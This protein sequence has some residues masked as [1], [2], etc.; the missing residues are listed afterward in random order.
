MKYYNLSGKSA[1]EDFV[2]FK[3]KLR[4]VQVAVR[5][6]KTGGNDNM[7]IRAQRSPRV[8]EDW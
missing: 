6:K 7:P 3:I 5:K 8:R 2:I 1:V 4:L